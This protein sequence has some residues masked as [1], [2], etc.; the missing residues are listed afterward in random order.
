MAIKEFHE[1][2]EFKAKKKLYET[3]NDLFIGDHDTVA[4]KYLVKHSLEKQNT[5]STNHLWQTRKARSF[6]T[7]HLREYAT[8]HPHNRESGIRSTRY[9]G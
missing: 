8:Y 1:S 3:V 9:R 6:Y 2:L 4:E 5:D 7:S